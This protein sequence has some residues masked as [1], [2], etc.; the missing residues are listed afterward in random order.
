MRRRALLAVVVAGASASISPPREDLWSLRGRRAVVTGGSK[1]LGRAIV[2]EL[3]RQG[4]DVITCARDLT[5]LE[6]LL[7]SEPRLTAVKADVA[8]AVGR[9]ELLDAVDER[10]VDNDSE[11]GADTGAILDLLVNNVGTNLRRA[12]VDYTDEEYA[13]LH[14]TNQA[15]AFH[16]SRMCFD[17]LRRA[18]GSVVCVSSVSGSTVD[19]TGAPYHMNKAAMEH[20]TRCGAPTRVSLLCRRRA[21]AT[22]P[23]LPRTNL[24]TGQ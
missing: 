9:R 1:G 20:M 18:K 22:A 8:T 10:F 17:A 6:P 15:S 19:S 14:E 7:A 11:T 24:G 4:C 13:L 2:D 12:S 3:L 16:L 23:A 21:R 5:P